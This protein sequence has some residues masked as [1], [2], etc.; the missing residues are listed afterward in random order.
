MDDYCGSMRAI[1]TYSAHLARSSRSCAAH[2][3]SVSGLAVSANSLARRLAMSGEVMASL[4]SALS[5]SGWARRC[6]GHRD[7]EEAGGGEAR[8]GLWP[9]S[10]G[11]DRAG[12][13]A[14]G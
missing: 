1:R 12:C 9:G 2:C 7:G 11:R 5:F 14:A 3:P 10:A 13:A 6:L 8:E 4:T